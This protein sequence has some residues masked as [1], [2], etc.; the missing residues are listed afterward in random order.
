MHLPTL[1][2]QLIYNASECISAYDD[3]LFITVWNRACERKFGVS[4]KEAVGK[5]LFDLFP[6][7]EKDYRVKCMKEAITLGKSFFFSNMVYQYTNQPHYYSQYIR[8]FKHS[9]GTV[10]VINIV[11]D[12]DQEERL[13]V[14]YFKSFFFFE[15]RLV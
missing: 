1:N 14:K 6:H 10:G 4:E 13:T 12:H 3:R 9:T 8:P 7:I 5:Q 15:T 11:R 2:Q